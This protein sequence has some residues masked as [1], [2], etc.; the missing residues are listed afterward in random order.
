MGPVFVPATTAICFPLKLLMYGP[1]ESPWHAATVLCVGVG[2]GVFVWVWVW[3]YV[4]IW[5]IE[6]YSAGSFISASTPNEL[7]GGYEEEKERA[8][9]RGG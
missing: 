5:E 9:L 2:A 4:A 6:E 8:E 3:V 1:P 7:W